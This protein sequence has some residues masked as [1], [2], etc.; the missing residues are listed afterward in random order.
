M[1]IASNNHVSNVDTFCISD[2]QDFDSLIDNDTLSYDFIRDF[3]YAEDETCTSTRPRFDLDPVTMTEDSFPDLNTV[4]ESTYFPTRQIEDISAARIQPTNTMQHTANSYH[5]RPDSYYNESDSQH[6]QS[7]TPNANHQPDWYHESSSNSNDTNTSSNNSVY[8]TCMSQWASKEPRLWSTDDVLDWLY[9]SV[10]KEGVDFGRLR[11]EAFQN[12]NGVQLCS[13]TQQE[14]VDKEPEYGGLLF[15]SF[16]KLLNSATRISSSTPPTTEFQ[17]NKKDQLSTT[18]SILLDATG[19]TVTFNGGWIGSI[20]SVQNLQ[21]SQP[22]SQT[23]TN[24]IV[25]STTNATSL[26][27]PASGPYRYP[28]PLTSTFKPKRRPGRPRIRK[29]LTD[30]EIEQ[31]KQRKRLKNQHLWEFLYDALKNPGYNPRL[32]KWED[33]MEGVFRFVQS[34]RMAHVWGDLKNNGNMNYEKLSRAMRHYYRRGILE[35]VEGRRLVYKFTKTAIDK[36]KS[37]PNKT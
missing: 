20:P 21:Q 5:H 23:L 15:T 14:F 22:R 25:I 16:K 17:Q 31:E 12:V 4:E 6:G 9:S 28:Q 11:G 27:L 13:M 30:A 2:L 29:R 19:I 8:E 1:P 10:E 34:E 32:M 37:R 24:G 3:L 18:N 36:L 33:E 35:R 7:D 26:P